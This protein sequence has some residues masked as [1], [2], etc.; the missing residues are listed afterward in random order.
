MRKKIKGFTLIEALVVV[1]IIGVLAVIWVFYGRDHIKL[2]AMSEG[3]MFIEK[4]VAQEKMYL[5]EHGCFVKTPGNK[6]VSKLD[7]LGLDASRNNKYYT[8]FK[9][10]EYGTIIVVNMYPDASRYPEFSNFVVT[11]TYNTNTD[12]IEYNETYG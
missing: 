9:I 5:N 1:S 11:G 2:A 10:Q 8:T 4:I 7:A 12:I 6:P 3:R